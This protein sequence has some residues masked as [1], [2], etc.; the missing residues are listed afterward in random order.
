MIKEI[1]Q[2]LENYTDTGDC[3]ATIA[4]QGA[5]PRIADKCIAQVEELLAIK[6]IWQRNYGYL[7]ND[8]MRLGF[9]SEMERVFPDVGANNEEVAPLNYDALKFRSDML[10]AENEALKAIEIW[11]RRVIENE[12]T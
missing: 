4:M 7:H 3:D 1:K 6:A 5:A 9:E 11:N 2:V 12:T 8:D 10:E